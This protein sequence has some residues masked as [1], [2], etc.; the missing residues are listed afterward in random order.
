MAAPDPAAQHPASPGRERTAGAIVRRELIIL[1]IA[2]ACGFIL[3]PFLIWLVGNRVLGPYIHGQDAAAGTGPL[4]LL[5][6]YFAGLGHGSVI[7]WCVAVGPYLLVLV[8][9]LLYRLVR[10]APAA[11]VSRDP[12]RAPRLDRGR[13]EPHL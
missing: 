5:A 6:D 2:S 8:V 10:P 1:G 3:M 7:F 9:R 4:R 11:P 13:I 12:P